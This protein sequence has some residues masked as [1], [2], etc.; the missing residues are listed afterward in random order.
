MSRLLIIVFFIIF[1]QQMLADV[2]GAVSSEQVSIKVDDWL[3]SYLMNQV[4]INEFS[5]LQSIDHS[6]K[7]M[8]DVSL[9]AIFAH[10]NALRLNQ[11]WLLSDR[12]K[13]DLTAVKRQFQVKSQKVPSKPHFSS[14]LY[15]K[16]WQG[17]E[18]SFQQET[19]VCPLGVKKATVFRKLD[20]TKEP[21]DEI[22]LKDIVVFFKSWSQQEKLCYLVSAMHEKPEVGEA[23]L[24]DPMLVAEAFYLTS[25]LPE[26][27]YQLSKILSVVYLQKNN[28]P[29]ALRQLLY[30]TEQQPSFRL[31]YDLVQRI[32][33]MKQQGS[34]KVA[35][36]GI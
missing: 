34:G 11:N 32:F 12:V 30:L 16:L 21:T 25:D 10:Q 31:A 29:E 17:L 2:K 3:N 20:H 19:P 14:S 22:R 15:S 5:A 26:H 33:S 35:I 7:E 36:K 23:W 8:S 4:F 9:R 1:E 27:R 13:K 18:S 6:K 28:F 24:F